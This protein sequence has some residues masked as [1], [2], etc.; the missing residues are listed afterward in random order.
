MIDKKKIFEFLVNISGTQYAIG[1]IIIYFFNYIIGY[2]IGKEF[3]LGFVTKALVTLITLT[4]FVL[5]YY[6]SKRLNSMIVFYIISAGIIFQIL[7]FLFIDINNMESY[8][9]IN[10]IITFSVI[11][12]GLYLIFSNAKTKVK[13]NTDVKEKF[14]SNFP[15]IEKKVIV[16]SNENSLHEKVK[17]IDYDPI[18]SEPIDRENAIKRIKEIKDLFE[19]GILSK[20]EYEKLAAKYKSIIME[21]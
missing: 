5:P 10:S 2:F 19:E 8:N 6:R 7:N 13:I 17:S 21:D 18:D 14:D 11:P 3:G 15:K 1:N 16:E 12:F 20:E 9:A 4:H